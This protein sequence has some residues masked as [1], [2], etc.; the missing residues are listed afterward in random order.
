V[1]KSKQTISSTIS[2]LVIED[3]KI[4]VIQIFSDFNS[5]SC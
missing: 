3:A 5:W 1:L 4:C 2:Y